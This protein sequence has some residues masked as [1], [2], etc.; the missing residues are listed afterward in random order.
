M[1]NGMHWTEAEYAAYLGRRPQEAG[2]AARPHG[3][4]EQEQRALLLWADTLAV[5]QEPRLAWLYHTPNGGKRSKATAGR[6]KAMGVKAGVPDLHLPV[7]SRG[8]HGLWL[9]MK[10]SGQHPTPAQ[11]HWLESLATQGH[12]CGVYTTWHKAAEHLCWYLEREDLAS[13]ITEG[14]P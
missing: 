4:E 10:A 3:Y 2:P 14:T 12:C 7:P 8:Y 13:A 1:S 9:E 5:A 6:L 11:V